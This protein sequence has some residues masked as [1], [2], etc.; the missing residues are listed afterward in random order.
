[1]NTT[2]R[3]SAE[4]RERASPG[5][6]AGFVNIEIQLLAVTVACLAWAVF[7]AVVQGIRADDFWRGAVASLR[8]SW[9]NLAVAGFFTALLIGPSAVN[10]VRDLFTKG[11]SSE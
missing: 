4:V 6:R 11:D 5:R 3:Y 1:M 2:K 10:A 8:I 9:V 7:F